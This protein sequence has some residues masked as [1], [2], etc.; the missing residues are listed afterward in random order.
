MTAEDALTLAAALTGVLAAGAVGGALA[1]V[2]G[3]PPVVGQ[4]CAGVLLGPL[5]VGSLLPD[6]YDTIFTADN[7]TVIARLGTVAAAIYLFTA[8]AS[9][10][11]LART[12][13][14][15]V[16]LLASVNAIVSVLGT[17]LIIVLIR[18]L[19]A[20]SLD[21]WQSCYLA[22]VFTV[23]AVPVLLRIIDEKRLM[24]ERAARYA[25]AIAVS[26]DVL[27]WCLVALL[28]GLTHG[29]VLRSAVDATIVVAI[30]VAWP[31][32]G[33]PIR[34]AIGHPT[35]A[36]AVL[37]LAALCA[38]IGIGVS[39]LAGIDV[40]IGALLGGV[41]FGAGRSGRPPPWFLRAGWFRSI[42]THLALPIFFAS[43]GLA[44]SP[45]GSV[46]TLVSL[47]AASSA[48][49]IGIRAITIYGCGRWISLERTELGTTFWLSCARGGTELVLLKVGLNSGLLPAALYAPAVLM[50]IVTTVLAGVLART[51]A[52]PVTA[53][54]VTEPATAPKGQ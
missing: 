47:A 30:L 15:D 48:V 51:S 18:G 3:V 45:S 21:G 32:V 19:G 46:A 41:I 26:T 29:S 44:A 28:D 22:L 13:R 11:D 23:C 42:L 43:A 1:R 31:F 37:L 38:A 20:A 34:R 27:V 24:G 6:A 8:G 36:R 7:K 14:R 2:I 4:M 5:L 40:L 49:A 52:M 10:P 17:I 35:S 39:E 50:A 54:P 33:S 53:I 16:G 9:H 12:P 25:V